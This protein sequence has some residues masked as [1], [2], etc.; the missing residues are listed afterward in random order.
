[1]ELRRDGP[2]RLDAGRPD[3]R[4]RERDEHHDDER[5]RRRDRRPG[6]RRHGDLHLHRYPEVTLRY[7]GYP[8]APQTD[9]RPRRRPLRVHRRH[10]HVP[11]LGDHHRR[12]HPGRPR[13]ARADH[14][15]PHDHRVPPRRHARGLLAIRQR[16]LRRYDDPAHVVRRPHR[17]LP[18]RPPRGGPGLHDHEPLAPHTDPEP[19]TDAD[20]KHLTHPHPYLHPS[21]QH[22]AHPD[23]NPHT[24][25][26]LPVPTPTP[27]P[28]PQLPSTGAT[29]S[30]A[31]L[32][33][34][35][36]ALILTGTTLLVLRRRLRR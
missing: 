12:G 32:A 18:G 17:L 33:V 13:L 27:S 25:Y 3:L 26:P 21:P 22:L 15:P 14:R 10:H 5:L 28:S 24:P 35:S 29:T 4:L 36:A 16:G 19:H 11:R 30:P 8:R 6:R 20:T 2:R 34:L 9:P 23:A 7:Y 1:M 31:L